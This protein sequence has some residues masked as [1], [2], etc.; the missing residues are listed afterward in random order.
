MTLLL[1]RENN[2][3]II[4]KSNCK[5]RGSGPNK[6]RQMDAQTHE[7]T[8]QNL[9]YDNYV[10]LIAIR[11]DKNG[12]NCIKTPLIVTTPCYIIVCPF[13]GKQPV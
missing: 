6:S 12:H 7:H 3:K 9:C 1:I 2:C 8:S 11:L 10:F 5:D 13:D 4:V